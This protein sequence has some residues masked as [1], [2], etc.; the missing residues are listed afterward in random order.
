MMKTVREIMTQDVQAIQP[1]TDLIAAAR[2]MRDLNVGSLPVVEG[3]RLLGI[4]TD[5]DI[6]IRAIAEGR[7]PQHE[8]A[9]TYATPNPVCVSS[10]ASLKEATDLMSHHQIRRLPVVDEGRLVG[11]L[12]LGDVAVEGGKDKLSGQALEE[13]SEGGPKSKAV[14]E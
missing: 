6:V 11:F 3:D 4:I 14:G 10:S 12:A 1:Q 8:V 5:R 9:H 13:I 7:N 2:M